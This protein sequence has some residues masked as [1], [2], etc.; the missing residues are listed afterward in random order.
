MKWRHFFRDFAITVLLWSY[1]TVG[2]LLLFAPFY[3]LAYCFSGNKPRS[4]Q[5]LNHFFYKGFFGLVKRLI[6]ACRWEIPKEVEEIR[7]SVI[8][9]NHRSYIDPILLISLY[10]RHTTIAKARLFHIPV[11]G[12]MLTLSG[13]IPSKAEGRFGELIMDVMA[14]MATFIRSGGNVFIFPE[15]TRTRDGRIGH[16]NKG[17]FKIARMCRAPVTVLFIENTEKLLPP[18]KFLFNTRRPNRITLSKVAKIQ[19][20]YEA[21]GF[22]IKDPMAEVYELLNKRNIEKAA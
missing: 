21:D 10:P 8:V 4:F 6:P 2:F 20:D 19:P 1:Y 16:L 3:F 9:C 14:R 12:K 7:S 18:G 17:A 15:G 22:S 5:K 13:Y 11:F